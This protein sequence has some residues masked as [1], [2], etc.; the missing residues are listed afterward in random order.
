MK[1]LIIEYASALGIDDP[2]IYA[3]GRAMLEGLTDDFKFK[4]ADYLISKNANFQCKY[5]NPVEIKE[6]LMDWL[7]KN[8]AAYDA[9]LLIAPEEDF[10]LHKITELI[11]KRG[12]KVIGSSSQAV[13]ACSDKFRMYEAL[14]DKVNIIK[15]EKVFFNEI[16]NYSPYFESKKVIKPADGVS[17]S[18]ITIV[19][20][21]DDLKKAAGSMQTNLPY[22]IVQDFIEGISASVS[23][24]S[25]GEEAVPLSLNLQKIQFED[26]NL[27]YD[28][29][30]VPLDHDMANEA[31]KVAK[32][33]VES[34]KGLKGY[35][36]VDVIIG[37]TVHIVEVNSRVTTP[38]VALRNIL[39]FNLGEAIFDSVYGIFPQEI[40]LNGKVSFYKENNELK[41][42]KLN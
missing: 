19:G 16:D 38:Y 7:D 5:C 40:N 21:L 27:N 11:E 9:C 32:N 12:V 4:N 31:K 34:I 29:G 20:S 15:T 36:G 1:I 41:I 30:E 17:C 42:N 18:G 37:D 6:D 10:T 23:L 13:L 33:A 8:I 22:F 2:S 3:E 26:N 25:T 24:I 28:G 14:K 35:V 39:N